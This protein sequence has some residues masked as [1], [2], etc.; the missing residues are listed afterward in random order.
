MRKVLVI[1]DNTDV[2]ENTAE[3]LEL[4][5]HMV[6][7]AE[8]GKIGLEKVS[9]FRPDI[10]V[11][12]VMM[13]VMDGYSVLQELAKNHDTSNIPFIF[14]TAKTDRSEIRL[15]MNLGADDYLTKPFQ[16]KELLDAIGSRLRKSDFLKDS[17]DKTFEGLNNFLENASLY[18]YIEGISKHRELRPYK[19]KE[20]VFKEGQKANKLYFI[21]KG[22][23]KTFKLMESG[24]EF[25]TGLWGAGDF[26][27]QL[28]LLG[29]E[30]KYTENA[31][32]MENAEIGSIPK[33]D[34]IKLLYGDHIV[35]QKFIDMIS[36]NL[37]A[38]QDQLINMAFSSVRQRAARA[39]LY[40]FNKGMI[41]TR[42]NAGI[43]IP[44]DDFAGIIGTAK[45]T[46]VRILTDFKNEGII[47]MDT[48]RR[49]ILLEPE[50]L[51]S[52]AGFDCDPSDIARK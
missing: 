40:L 33:E 32:I 22:T 47:A 17:I 18:T 3:M 11:C 50:V 24:K 23:V 2:R 14:L 43:G 48:G 42:S 12:D 26:I 19:K 15:G 37:V 41:K 34:F 4:E 7:T 45:E 52:E 25:V 1:E 29:S 8:N 13:P 10:I 36:N 20:R 51:K 6:A 35:S 31:T 46:A 49:I 28:S 30:G 21:E 5:G 44:R 38:V 16:K 27:G 9:D 39:L